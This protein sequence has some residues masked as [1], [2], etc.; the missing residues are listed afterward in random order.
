MTLPPPPNPNFEVVRLLGNGGQADVYL[1]RHHRTRT[2]YACKFLREVWDPSE[3][4]RFQNEGHRQARLAGPNVVPVVGWNFDGP[5]PFLLLEYM[6]AGSLADDLRR[7]SVV[8][9]PL[10]SLRIVRSLA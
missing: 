6:P 1:V 5:R 7:R 10:A 2:V 4:T 8:R 9:P 3:R